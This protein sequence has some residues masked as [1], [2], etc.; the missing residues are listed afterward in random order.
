[1]MQSKIAWHWKQDF[2]ND[3]YVKHPIL[4]LLLL[5][6]TIFG[7]M[8][9]VTLE[10]PK[11]EQMENQWHQVVETFRLT[12]IKKLTSSLFN[13]SELLIFLDPTRFQL[14]QE[15]LEKSMNSF[16]SEYYALFTQRDPRTLQWDMWNASVFAMSAFT[17]IGKKLKGKYESILPQFLHDASFR[18][19]YSECCCYASTNFCLAK[20]RYV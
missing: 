20:S 5:V 2:W 11:Q 10:R 12:T 14:A 1:M 9:F 19:M 6:Y 18:F 15:I 3:Y 4:L 7:A 17:T 16:E 8:V 13:T